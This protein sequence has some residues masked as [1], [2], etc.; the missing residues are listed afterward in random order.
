M[1]YDVG[2]AR[3]III[4]VALGAMLWAVIILAII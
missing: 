2:T 4:G 3:G 1:K